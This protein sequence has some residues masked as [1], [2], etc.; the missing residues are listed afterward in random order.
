[1]NGPVVSRL[2][3]AV[4][5]GTAA[6]ACSSCSTIEG[7]ADSSSTRGGSACLGRWADSTRGRPSRAHAGYLVWR[8]QRGWHLRTAQGT[9][10]LRFVAR[11][12]TA[13][14][15]R[16]VHAFQLEPGDSVARHGH[17]IAV[18]FRTAGRDQDG[19]DFQVRCGR[20]GFE[21]GTEGKAWPPRRI[22][23]GARA[24]APAQSFAAFDPASSGVEGRVLTGPS[25]P[26]EGA[27]ECRSRD[28]KPVRTTVDVKTAEGKF[29]KPRK[30][31]SVATDAE[32]RFRVD[33]PAGDYLL[34]PRSPGPS[35]TPTP[36]NAHVEAGL[37]TGVKLRLDTGLR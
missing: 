23:V 36:T 33:L 10:G 27:P 7:A 16:S 2:R 25:C 21:L 30:V 28:G 8:D 6:A 17:R 29:A 31:T 4:L 15:L 22:Y 1:M 13:R 34:E 20:I 18:R 26:V 14:P 11:I 9:T 5:V 35:L 12:D 32:G 3:V 19:I 37:V 24:R